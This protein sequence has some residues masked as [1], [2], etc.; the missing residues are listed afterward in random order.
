VIRHHGCPDRII[1][2]NDTRLRAGFW[3]ALTARLGIEMKITSSY[4]PR[5]NGKVENSGFFE[6]SHRRTPELVL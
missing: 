1:A 4:H 2:D 3:E 5:A 6:T